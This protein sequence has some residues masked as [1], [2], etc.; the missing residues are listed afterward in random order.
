MF[1]H[2]LIQQWHY[3]FNLACKHTWYISLGYFANYKLLEPTATFIQLWADMVPVCILI[4]IFFHWKHHVCYVAKLHGNFFA[5]FRRR[6]NM[7][8]H[9]LGTTM[10][11]FLLSGTSRP[12]PDWGPPLNC[13]MV[14]LWVSWQLMRERMNKLM[15][16]MGM[17]WTICFQ[18]TQTLSV[19]LQTYS[20]VH[21]W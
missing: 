21:V 14:L 5:D 9:R 11:L 6:M 7:S 19:L 15:R 16:K 17:S 2:H 10:R 4:C 20:V 3:F 18:D 8:K 12:S 13:R 1:S